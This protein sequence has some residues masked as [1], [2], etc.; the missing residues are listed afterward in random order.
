MSV[1]FLIIGAGGHGRVVAD[2]IAAGGHDV[3]GF[4]DSNQALHG[5]TVDGLKVLGGD[6]Y[7]A[8]CTPAGIRLANGIGAVSSLDLRSRI[9]TRLNAAGYRF[10]PL[11]HPRAI[12][13]VTATIGAGAQIMAG[14]VVQAGA[15]IGENVI[16]NT[17]AI[18]DHDCQVGRHAHIAP[19]ATLC[20]N[21]QAGEGCYIGASSTVIQGVRIGAG[22]FIAAGSVVIADVSDAARMAGVPAKVMGSQ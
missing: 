21:V 22:A 11:V 4:L 20:G 2:L 18:V 15:R 13:A 14:A 7:L 5:Q 19:G 1:P 10:E 3:L 12:V 8:K 9:F 16:V 17:G 6:D